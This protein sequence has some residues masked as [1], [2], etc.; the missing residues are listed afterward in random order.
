MNADRIISM[1]IN[2]IIR[3]VLGR[4]INAGID[5]ISGSRK[6]DGEKPVPGGEEGTKRARQMMKASRRIGRF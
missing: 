2:Q 3:R 4:G 5:A 6:K 1:V